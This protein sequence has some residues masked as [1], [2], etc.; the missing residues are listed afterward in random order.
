MPVRQF[1]AVA[2]Q[3]PGQN[4]PRIEIRLSGPASIRPGKSLEVQR[5]TATLTN[6]SAESQ[7]LFVREGYLMNV[8][9]NWTVTDAKGQPLGMGL[10][11]P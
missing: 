2:S 10:V 7:I 9:W 3:G 6:R 11:N 4:I 5:F 8:G 1:G